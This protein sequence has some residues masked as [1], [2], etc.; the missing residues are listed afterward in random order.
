MDDP[1]LAHALVVARQQLARLERGDVDG[2]IAG[3]D[4]YAAACGALRAP[5][6]SGINELVDLDNRM[7]I[8]LQQAKDGVGLKLAGM[9][10]RRRVTGVY[11]AP[12]ASTSRVVA[13]G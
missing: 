9:H 8:L 3:L 2:Y 7:G 4:Q 12:A 10:R 5:V 6:A 11:F 1:A 13:R